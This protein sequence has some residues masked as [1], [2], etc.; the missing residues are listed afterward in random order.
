MC[1]HLLY[2]GSDTLFF[3]RFKPRINKKS[4][5]K[6]TVDIFTFVFIG[7]FLRGTVVYFVLV[8]IT[9]EYLLF[10]KA[11]LIIYEP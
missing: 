9:F 1:F 2:K 3:I 7:V 10:L 6:C 4:M 11:Y 5:R 8:T